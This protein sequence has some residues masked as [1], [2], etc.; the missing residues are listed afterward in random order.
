MN[1]VESIVSQD[2]TTREPTEDSTPTQSFFPT[3]AVIENSL[4]ASTTKPET[5]ISVP[6]IP[7]NLPEPTSAVTDT[8]T[9]SMAAVEEESTVEEPGDIITPDAKLET[10]AGQEED[11]AEPEV[12]DMPPTEHDGGGEAEPEEQ[13]TDGKATSD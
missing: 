10:I 12:E 6:F 1:P 7:N 11:E 8:E 2:D 9:P 3:V 5:D 13:V 4:E